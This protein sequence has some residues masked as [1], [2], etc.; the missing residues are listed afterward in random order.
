MKIENL[1]I[2]IDELISL[3]DLVL[4]TRKDSDFGSYVSSERFNE[5]RSASLSFLKN[6]FN[7]THP[8]YKEFEER[9]RGAN[10]YSVEEGRGILKAAKSEIFGGWIFTI[11]GLISS[12]I[13]SDF[14]EMSEY[15]LKENWKDAAAVMT[16]GVLEEHLRQLCI[17]HG[18][19]IDINK[20]GKMIPKKAESLNTDLSSAGVYNILDQKNVTAWLDLRNKAAHAK[21]LEYS[22]EQV[23][24][25]YSGILNFIS[26]TI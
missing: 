17:K 18:I 20:N 2:R 11:K 26:R 15:L 23:E 4:Q 8:F 19:S 16:G 10:P 5:F 9:A 1:K 3:A 13:F 21:Y 6:T 24:I 14:L 7:E 22:K 25:M 12:E